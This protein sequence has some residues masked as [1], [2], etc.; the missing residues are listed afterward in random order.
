MGGERKVEDLKLQ[1]ADPIRRK[2]PEAD[3]KSNLRSIRQVGS[4]KNGRMSVGMHELLG[5]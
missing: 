5:P 1:A 4:R 2:G 3:E